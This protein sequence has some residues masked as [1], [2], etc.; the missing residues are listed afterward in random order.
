MM[1]NKQLMRNSEATYDRPTYISH[2]TTIKSGWPY[3]IDINIPSDVI[4]GDLI[5]I[6][7]CDSNNSSTTNW[8]FSTI[9]GFTR[10][11]SY[12]SSTYDAGYA[13]YWKIADGT[14]SSF[15]NATYTSASIDVVA[16]CVHIKGA[17]QTTP[18]GSIGTADG[19]SFSTTHPITGITGNIDDLG[20]Y[21][22]A[23]DGA[24]GYPFTVTAG[25]GWEL[26]GQ[27]KSANLTTGSSGTFGTKVYSSTA[28][29]N[30][31]ID[32][33]SSDGCTFV[34]FRIQK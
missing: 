15:I 3:T 33:S 1:G 22:F 31:T 11:Q 4:S 9:S 28:A 21:I 12:A 32:T 34:Q 8:G 6:L 23:F 13:I 27:D 24:D 29:E 20:F 10:A 7:L 2:L 30:V 14:E 25:V 19:D 17:N 26:I 16:F 18:I 5:L